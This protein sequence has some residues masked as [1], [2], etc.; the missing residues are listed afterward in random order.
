MHD[1]EVEHERMIVHVRTG[2]FARLLDALVAE[3]YQAPLALS[4]SGLVQLLEP[5]SIPCGGVSM[6]ASNP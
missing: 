3:A 5:L 1:M 4:P 6:L 2:D